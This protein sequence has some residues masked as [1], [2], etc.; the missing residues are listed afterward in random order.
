[1]RNRIDSAMLCDPS[2]VAVHAPAE[3]RHQIVDVVV[4]RRA[5]PAC[6]ERT[7]LHLLRTPHG[8]ELVERKPRLNSATLAPERCAL[9]LAGRVLTWCLSSSGRRRALLRKVLAPR[10]VRP[11]L[12][13]TVR[14]PADTLRRVLR[15]R[16][17]R[18]RIPCSK[19][20]V[21][22]LALGSRWEKRRYRVRRAMGRGGR[23]PRDRQ[24]IVVGLARRRHLPRRRLFRPH[25]NYQARCGVRPRPNPASLGSGP[26]GRSG[27]CL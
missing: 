9:F 16:R 22:G 12:R 27:G 4:G 26:R 7:T 19:P 13:P 23:R 20:R 2:D 17:R 10:G 24:Q 18:Y 8:G 5:R 1:M 14:V 21:R 6:A 25:R 3:V 11:Q 15:K